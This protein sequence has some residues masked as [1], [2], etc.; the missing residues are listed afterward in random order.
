MMIGSFLTNIIA[1]AILDVLWC[2][3]IEGPL[4]IISAFNSIFNYLSGKFIQELL[5]KTSNKFSWSNIPVA[6]WG[7][8]IFAAVVICFIFWSQFIALLFTETKEMKNKFVN[9]IKMT[10]LGAIT[11]FFIPVGFFFLNQIIIFFTANINNIFQMPNNNNIADLLWH[12]GDSSWDGKTPVDPNYAP[13]GNI[14]EYNIIIEIF[15]VWFILITM[16]LVSMILVQKNL[17]LFFLFIISPIVAATMANDHGKRMN[18]W[19]DMVIAKS[20]ATSATIVS[21]YT[22][23]LA[24]ALIYSLDLTQFTWIEQQILRV[25]LICGGAL[26]CYNSSTIVA[27]LVSESSG[28]RE[29]MSTLTSM[30]AMAMGVGGFLGMRKR[31]PYGRGGGRGGKGNGSSGGSNDRNG[32]NGED[33][34]NGGEDDFRVPNNGLSERSGALGFLG[35]TLSHGS[36]LLYSA[37][38]PMVDYHKSDESKNDSLGTQI[39]KQGAN[40]LL[41]PARGVVSPFKS[42]VMNSF[43]SVKKSSYDVVKQRHAHENKSRQNKTDSAKAQKITIN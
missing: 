1:T 39:A 29:G 35:D 8:A 5:F 43:G 37:F 14:L 13:P 24:L 4:I 42:G 23:M 3:F 12:L 18:T 38:K 26:A 6:F 30:A 32:G 27:S 20:I 40:L 7:F 10:A 21:Y 16:G 33:G 11:I 31:N 19:K 41:A 34:D 17:E 25:A 28:M 36:N 9:C 22:F 15:A 2:V